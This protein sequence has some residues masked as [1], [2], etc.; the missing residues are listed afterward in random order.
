MDEYK[1]YLNPDH[2]AWADH[3]CAVAKRINFDPDNRD[4]QDWVASWI[5]NAMM[6]GV[7]RACGH[8]RMLEDNPS[9]VETI[10]KD[11]L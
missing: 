5:A 7:D 6:H 3:F 11:I 10:F 8:M 2:V 1:L 4:H 9:F